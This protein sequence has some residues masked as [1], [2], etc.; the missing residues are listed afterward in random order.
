MFERTFIWNMF[1]KLKS[2]VF[3]KEIK[4]WSNGGWQNIIINT[5]T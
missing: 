1:R 2:V 3:L 5:V 4:N